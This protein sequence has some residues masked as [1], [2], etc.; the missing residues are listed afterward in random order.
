M[1]LAYFVIPHRFRWIFLLLANYYFYMYLKV[2]YGILLMATT[3]VV[4]S[5][6]LLMDGRPQRIK[7]LFL[8]A[9][10]AVNLGILFAFKYLNF[11]SGIV[12]SVNEIIRVQGRIQKFSLLLPIGISFYTFQALGYLIDVYRGTVGAQRH[13]G[14]LA[15]FLSFFPQL[16]A[17]PIGR[18]KD[19]L[20]QFDVKHA[21]DPAR[22]ADGLKLMMWG[23]FIKMVVADNL[24]GI[25]D[26]VYNN[27]HIY[28]GIHYL[29][30]SLAFTY[31]IFSDFAGYSFIAQGSALVLGFTLITNFDRPYQSVS[32]NDF[33]RR[34][35]ISLSTWFRDYLYI[36][37]GGNR[38]SRAR[39]VFNIVIVFLSSGLWHGAN[40]TFVLWG[41]IHALFS[42]ASLLTRNARTAVVRTLHLES[43]P[44]IHHAI[45]ITITFILVS[46]AWIFFRA[47][48]IGDALYIIREM[49]RGV[50]YYLS[51][52]FCFML[53]ERRFAPLFDLLRSMDIDIPR[54]VLLLFPIGILELI[55]NMYTSEPLVHDKMRHLHG[56]LRFFFY[57][58][59]IMCI[60][61]LGKFAA[62]QFIYFQ[63]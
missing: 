36:P 57:F 47:N 62:T 31:Q 12:N 40:W 38:V 55:N 26:M 22:V 5:A 19:L 48:T 35:H 11:F 23:Y 1:V 24:T 4:Y 58:F 51:N 39:Q 32:I 2:E 63:F 21:F 17:G 3:V 43:L 9:G 61:L 10:I 46:F 16:L 52:S 18:A 41:G 28:E 59:I 13:F 34:W 6:A 49:P 45:R 15:L 8:I 20:G 30:A 29:I 27:I 37:L 14:K 54:L 60:L 53:T 50:A 25:V 44:R 33:W 42:S 7:K 56:F